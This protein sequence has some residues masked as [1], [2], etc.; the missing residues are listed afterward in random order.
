MRHVVIH[1][2]GDI[3]GASC[4]MCNAGSTSMEK[5]Q[6]TDILPTFAVVEESDADIGHHFD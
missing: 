4:C 3:G 1:G 5:D 2:L 6:L